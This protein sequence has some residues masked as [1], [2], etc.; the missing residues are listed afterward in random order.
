MRATEKGLP[1]F[2]LLAEQTRGVVEAYYCT[3]AAVDAALDQDGPVGLKE[4]RK[5]SGEQFE[6]A[7]ILGEVDRREGANPVTFKNALDLLVQRRILEPAEIDSRGKGE[8]AFA[9]GGA[10]GDLPALR[11]RLAAAL[12]AR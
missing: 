2:R 10:F 3:V 6:R 7:A 5:A 12:A 11:E 9:R 8:E 1:V 4:L